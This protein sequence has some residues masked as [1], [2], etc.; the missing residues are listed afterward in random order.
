MCRNKASL[1]QYEELGHFLLLEEN[2]NQS[3]DSLP[4]SDLIGYMTSVS[5]D[6]PNVAS[7]SGFLLEHVCWAQI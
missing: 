6:D 7:V 1:E 5:S 2:M 3:R 4:C